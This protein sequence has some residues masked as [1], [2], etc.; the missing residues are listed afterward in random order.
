MGKGG[1]WGQPWGGNSRENRLTPFANDPIG[2]PTGE[3]LFLRDDETGEC[4]SPTPGPLLRH[5]TGR[6]LV[7]HTAGLTQFSR[8]THGIHHDLEIFLP[9]RDPHKF[10]VPTPP[11]ARPIA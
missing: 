9:P 3:A 1:G 8:A 2:D 6:C 7:R 4:W 10:S 11:N 5:P